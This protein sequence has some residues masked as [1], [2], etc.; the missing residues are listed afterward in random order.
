MLQNAFDDLEDDDKQTIDSSC[1]TSNVLDQDLVTPLR[2]TKL[3]LNYNMY[4]LYIYIFLFICSIMFSV[5]C[6]SDDR[7][8]YTQCPN[9]YIQKPNEI[10][11][12]SHATPGIKSAGMK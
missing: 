9:G 8:S 7:T 3:F 6:S 2:G 12:N 4:I 1:L 10:N 5:C 11:N